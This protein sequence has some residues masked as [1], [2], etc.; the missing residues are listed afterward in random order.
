[1]NHCREKR[2]VYELYETRLISIISKLC[3]RKLVDTFIPIGP[4]N[5]R[6]FQD[7]HNPK[8]SSANSR[9]CKVSYL[10]TFHILIHVSLN[11]TR[12]LILLRIFLK[13]LKN[14][15]NNRKNGK[16]QRGSKTKII[17]RGTV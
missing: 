3:L 16:K 15:S 9:F 11:I 1:M 7:S 14:N 13:T 4:L 8:T 5:T 12:F 10:R 2:K 6:K 17:F